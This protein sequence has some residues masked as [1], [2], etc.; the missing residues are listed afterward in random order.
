MEGQAIDITVALARI[1]K[2]DQGGI[3]LIYQGLP[4]IS[5]RFSWSSLETSVDAEKPD[6]THLP[7]CFMEF[8][9]GNYF[10]YHDKAKDAISLD[11]R[12]RFFK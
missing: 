6:K 9:L 2:L 8:V 3:D 1:K 7:L 12:P 4:R 10:R 11:V 5:A